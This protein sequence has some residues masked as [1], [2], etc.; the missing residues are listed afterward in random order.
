MQ[1]YS[2]DCPIC[3]SFSRRLFQKEQF[4]IWKCRS[5]GH[6]FLDLETTA[7]HAEIVYGD[8]YFNG[9]GAGY[10]GYL[11]DAD[12]VRG[13]DHLKLDV[14]TGSF[15]Q[16]H[17]QEQYDLVTMVQV[18]PHFWDLAQA[19]QSA[20]KLTASG[21]Y[22]LVETWNRESKLAKFFGENWHEYSPPSVLR[23]FAPE[24]LGVL[25]EQ[26]GFE[27]VDRGRPQKWISGAHVK[28]LVGHKLP[29]WESYDMPVH[30]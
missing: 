23:W 6:Q 21:G 3:Q 27:E 16:F 25:A 22:W 8:D 20:E 2:L 11:R 24:D 10:P 12:L 13:R 26:Y 9:G 15:E 14:R 18:I 28:S 7:H 4:W 1:H 29:P 5:C 17:A 30:C 19:L